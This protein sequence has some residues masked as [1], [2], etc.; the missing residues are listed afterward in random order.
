MQPK[1][2]NTTPISEQPKMVSEWEWTEAALRVVNTALNVMHD[3]EPDKKDAKQAHN[4]LLWEQEMH[5]LRRW[6]I[7]IHNRR[8]ADNVKRLKNG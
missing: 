2:M 8:I 3:K 1:R 4:R 7:S 5:E 6:A